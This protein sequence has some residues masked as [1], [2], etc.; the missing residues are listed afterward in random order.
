MKGLL[1][2]SKINLDFF[3]HLLLLGFMFLQD[4]LRGIVYNCDDEFKVIDNEHSIHL[5]QGGFGFLSG[6]GFWGRNL[7]LL[8]G[9]NLISRRC[10]FALV[11]LIFFSI[12]FF[13][14][15]ITPSAR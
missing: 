6:R 13:Y 9:I 12:Y 15:V 4:F 11:L 14:F 7:S 10:Y 3:I 5:G 8:Q 2:P 1:Y